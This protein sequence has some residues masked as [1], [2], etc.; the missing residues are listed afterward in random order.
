[1]SIDHIEIEK[2]DCNE[3]IKLNEYLQAY[4][5][6]VHP[7]VPILHKAAFLS[8]YKIYAPRAIADRIREIP[9]A[10][11]PEG[12]AVGLICAVLALG[13]MSLVETK[14]DPVKEESEN[15]VDKIRLQHYGEAMGFYKICCQLTTYAYDA[16]ETMLTFLLMV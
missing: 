8:L 6:N 7:L 2:R 13:A 11:T 10:S 16:L 12:R 4:F 5:N 14:I 15:G 3:M 9:D 1:L